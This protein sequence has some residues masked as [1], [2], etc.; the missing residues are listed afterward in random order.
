[1]KLL[2]RIKILINKGK[3]QQVETIIISERQCPNCA[4]RGMFVFNNITESKS[5]NGKSN[6]KLN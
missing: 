1:M 5:K 2:D 4:S 6:E 3:I